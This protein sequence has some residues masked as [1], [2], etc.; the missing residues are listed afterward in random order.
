MEKNIYLLLILTIYFEYNFCD[1]ITFPFER[2]L[3]SGTNETNFYSSYENNIIYT[4]ISIGIPEQI[5]KAQIKM[6]QYS[7]CIRNDSSYDCMKSQTYI[8][9][10]QDKIIYNADYSLSCTSGESFILGEEKIKLNEFSFLFTKKSMYNLDGI[11]GLQRYDYSGINLIVQLFSKKLINRPVF[12][13]YYNKTNDN[14]ELIIGEYPH[15]IE[16][17]TKEYPENKFKS[18]YLSVGGNPTSY[19]MALTSILWKGKI[20][21]NNPT[22]EISVDSGFI[23]ADENFKIASNEFFYPYIEQQICFVKIINNIYSLYTCKDIPELNISSFPNISFYDKSSNYSFVL[24]YND[25]FIKK[26]ENIYFMIIIGGL[27]NH[28]KVG[29]KFLQRNKIVFDI[30]KK[31]IGIY[32]KNTEEEE[33]KDSSDTHFTDLSDDTYKTDETNITDA[34][35]TDDANITDDTSSTEKATIENNDSNNVIYISIIS[36]CAVILIG[37]GGFFIYRY[38]GRKRIKKDCEFEGNLKLE[39]SMNT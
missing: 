37:L 25:I 28:W 15:L 12:F 10:D 3:P 6:S 11:I 33:E 27:A 2:I 36:V 34:T 20:I 32:D 17:Y 26:D 5:I 1:Y 38:L 19:K 24:T 30:D 31:I 9:Y 4:N 14:G 16:K 29:Y 7:F 18:I 35:I 8:R 39:E 23:F 22:I 21:E 13:F